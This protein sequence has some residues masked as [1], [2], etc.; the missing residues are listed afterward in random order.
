[1]TETLDVR[2]IRELNDALRRS[3]TGGQVVI[4]RGV[5]S[6]GDERRTRILDAV[7]TFEA[8]DADNN[9]YGE[10]DFGAFE[11]EGGRIL[12]K[13]DYYDQ[14]LTAHSPDPSDPS[15]TARVLTNHARQ[16]VLGAGGV[17]ASGEPVM[18]LP[19]EAP[20]FN[21][22]SSCDPLDVVQRDVPLR[23]LNATQVGAVHPRLKCQALL[24]QPALG[25]KPAHILRKHVSQGPLCVRFTPVRM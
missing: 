21:A 5:A 14:S 6:L 11:I 12:F 10:H 24:G 22:E 1:M 15:V 3:L 19:K 16:R 9:P 17:G 25:P 7:A 8:F 2:R 18:M 23:P 20:G 13:I 4:T